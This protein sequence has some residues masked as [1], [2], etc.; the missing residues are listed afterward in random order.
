VASSA[1]FCFIMELVA[2][3]KLQLRVTGALSK[4]VFG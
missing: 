4:G 2:V 3:D 1:Y